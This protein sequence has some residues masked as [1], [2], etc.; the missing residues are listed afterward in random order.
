MIPAV[1]NS[2]SPTRLE[3]AAAKGTG[4]QFR[5]SSLLW[6]TFTAA[7]TLAYARLFGPWA[8][9]LVLAVPLAAAVIGVWFGLML[10]RWQD[11]VYWAVVGGLL[12]S[13]FAVQPQVQGLMFYVWPLLFAIVGAFAATQP[14]SRSLLLVAGCSAAGLIAVFLATATQLSTQLDGYVDIA[15]GAIAG[16]AMSGLVLLVDWLRA[17]YRSSRDAWAAGLVFAAIAGNLWAAF[18]GGRLG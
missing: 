6:L 4:W 1:V 7:M 12:G 13:T 16:A 14:A 8:M 11:A 10:G 15:C 2:D 5:T 18:V 3:T 17:T 9:G